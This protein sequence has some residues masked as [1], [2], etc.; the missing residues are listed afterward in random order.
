MIVSTQDDFCGVIA[1]LN[2]FGITFEGGLDVDASNNRERS[3]TVTLTVPPAQMP[4]QDADRLRSVTFENFPQGCI[5][6]PGLMLRLSVR[7]YLVGGHRRGR[8]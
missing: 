3:Y 7:W 5:R 6:D 2:A 1:P 4:T 8:L